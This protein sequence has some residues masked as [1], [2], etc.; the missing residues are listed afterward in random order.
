[1]EC[2][3]ESSYSTLPESIRDH[4]FH[5]VFRKAGITFVGLAV[6]L[7]PSGVIHLQQ[8]ISKDAVNSLQIVC[9]PTVIAIIGD[10]GQLIGYRII[11]S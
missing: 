5:S 4:L 7:F 3:V 10:V 6:H 9:C 8:S 11:L 1:M 2:V